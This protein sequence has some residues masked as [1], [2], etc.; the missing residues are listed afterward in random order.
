MIAPSAASSPVFVLN[1]HYIQ[2]PETNTERIVGKVTVVA[3]RLNMFPLVPTMDILD[4]L[5]PMRPDD[6]CYR[7]LDFCSGGATWASFKWADDEISVDLKGAGNDLVLKRVGFKSTPSATPDYEV[8]DRVYA[9]LD[10]TQLVAVL[11]WEE[12]IKR[13]LR[14]DLWSHIDFGWSDFKVRCIPSSKA[15]LKE[16]QAQVSKIL[17]NLFAAPAPVLPGPQAIVAPFLDDDHFDDG[18][19]VVDSSSDDDDDDDESSSSSS[20]S[21]SGSSFRAPLPAGPCPYPATNRA[22][23]TKR[24]RIEIIQDDDSDC[25]SI[26]NVYKS[27]VF[28][29][30]TN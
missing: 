16:A 22:A 7:Q 18:P 1:H 13:V 30:S 2:M 3:E 5:V 21:S 20:S 26:T 6:C 12:A 27:R 24:C 8:L 23:A 11:F 9:S 15:L 25:K 4:R 17:E 29:S 14:S 19:V 10:L 28:F